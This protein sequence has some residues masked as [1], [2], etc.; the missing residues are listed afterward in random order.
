MSSKLPGVAI[1]MW[2]RFE[3][4]EVGMLHHV[5]GKTLRVGPSF[6]GEIK[7]L[8]IYDRYLRTSEAIG[9]FR[10]GPDGRS[11]RKP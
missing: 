2:L 10:A 8:R 9:N 4:L 6:K 1:D 11:A 3:L 7:A 5:G